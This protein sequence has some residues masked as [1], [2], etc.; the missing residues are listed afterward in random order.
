[1]ARVPAQVRQTRP[2]SA[3]SREPKVAGSE[4]LRLHVSELV[5]AQLEGMA[6]CVVGLDAGK[7]LCKGGKAS[8]ALGGRGVRPQLFIR[9]NSISAAPTL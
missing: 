1:M 5:D 9:M 3:F 6:L 7:V 2:W 8:C 4:F